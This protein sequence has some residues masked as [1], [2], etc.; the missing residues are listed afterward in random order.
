MLIV[1]DFA[2]AAIRHLLERSNAP[3]DAGLRISKAATRTSL[4][5]HL[6]RAPA[7]D[8]TVVI[9]N[10]GARVFLDEWAARLLDKKILDVTLGEGGRVEFFA[11]RT[12][13]PI[14]PRYN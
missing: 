14:E 2:A 4:K 7:P 3:D 11:T 6:K 12:R 10:N 13:Q 9:A 8:D 5:V 1:T